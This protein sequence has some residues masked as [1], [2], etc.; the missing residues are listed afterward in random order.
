MSAHINKKVKPDQGLGVNNIV[1]QVLNLNNAV[2]NRALN[3]VDNVSKS[4][5]NSIG[6]NSFNRPMSDYAKI[7]GRVVW[8]QIGQGGF[9]DVYLSENLPRKIVRKEARRLPANIRASAQKHIEA[10][11][12]VELDNIREINKHSNNNFARYLAKVYEI[13]S[14]NSSVYII[15]EYAN[16]GSMYSLLNT[17]YNGFSDELFFNACKHLV[18]GLW[19]LHNNVNMAHRDI[20]TENVLV[21]ETNGLTEEKIVFKL[22]DFGLSC[23]KNTCVCCAGTLD[24]LSKDHS[25]M[26][27]NADHRRNYRGFETEASADIYALC[28]VLCDWYGGAQN[29]KSNEYNGVRNRLPTNRRVNVSDL[30]D[31]PFFVN[32]IYNLYHA[33]ALVQNNEKIERMV[34]FIV[35]LI[36]AGFEKEPTTRYTHYNMLLRTYE[37]IFE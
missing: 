12:R 5:D 20:K 3:V 28:L 2:V 32:N 19:F 16:K 24:N 27:F 34:R 14:D 25:D 31:V 11:M 6:I 26:W 36:I 4:V 7:Y 10:Q 18:K 37:H 1:N 35:M 30:S 15:M 23:L 22:A 33:S 17:G 8:K 21:M 29:D 13:F 9:G